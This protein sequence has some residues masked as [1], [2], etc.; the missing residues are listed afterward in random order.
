MGADAQCS[1]FGIYFRS[2]SAIGINDVAGVEAQQ[3]CDV[4]SVV[5]ELMVDV[6]GVEAHHMYNPITVL[7]GVR[8]LTSAPCIG[9][10][11]WHHELC[12]TTEGKMLF[13]HLV[14]V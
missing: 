5:A 10:M 2:R 11:H 13:T 4:I 8:L 6:A 7:L 1:G 14:A 9:T 12:R 3:T